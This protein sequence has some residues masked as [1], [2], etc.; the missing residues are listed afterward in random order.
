MPDKGWNQFK[1][2]KQVSKLI[3]FYIKLEETS[4]FREFLSPAIEFFKVHDS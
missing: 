2:W 3:D 1:P 4:N